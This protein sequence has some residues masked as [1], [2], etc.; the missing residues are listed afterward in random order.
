MLIVIGAGREAKLS[1]AIA[2]NLK[3]NEYVYFAVL[4]TRLEVL[5]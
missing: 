1:R 4:L 2:L 5:P 3:M